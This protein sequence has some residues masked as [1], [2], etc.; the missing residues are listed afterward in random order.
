MNN[1]PR[2]EH[3]FPQFERADW[4]NLNGPWE[5]EIDY[6]ISGKDRKL[7]EKEQLDSEITVPFCPESE[8][9]GVGIKDFLNCVWYQKKVV[10]PAE[11]K[12]K[13]VVLHFGA[14]DYEATV[15][16][17]RKEVGTHV[18]G[19]ISF[20]FDIT[21]YLKDGE[22]V[23]TLCAKDD[24]RSGKQPCGKQCWEYHS[25]G[26]LY[27]RTTG[28][29]QT[30]WLEAMPKAYVKKVKYYPD[31]QSGTI[32]MELETVG[33]GNLDIAVSYEGKEM[34][35]A[36]LTCRGGAR[37]VTIPL[38]E[39]HL[40]E[41][42]HGRLYD[43]TF[44]YGGDQVKS[45]FGLRNVRL[46]GKK[47]L[48]NEK[49][50]FQRLILDQGFYPDGIYTAPTEE[51]L[52]RDIEISM[53]LG[54]NGARLHEKIFEPRFLYHCDRLGY[55]AWGEHANWGL[56]ITDPMTLYHFLPEWM[57]ALERDF[58]HPAIIGWC[59]FNETWDQ[60]G[61]KQY[62]DILRMVYRI[63][64]A[65]DTTRPCID[66]SGNFHVESDIWDVHDYEKDPEVFEKRYNRLMTEGVLEDKFEERQPYH[67]EATFVSEYGGMFTVFGGEEPEGGWG[68]DKPKTEE[69][70]LKRYEALT[71]ALLNN[72]QMFAFCYTQ[73]YDVEQ[74]MN[75][76]YSYDRKAKFDDQVIYRIN[77]K[78]AAIE[79]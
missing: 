47:F 30:V 48:I 8:L 42:G 26:C 18:G 1:I 56:D 76:F 6:S 64:K 68:Y 67:G 41:P 77:T 7:F 21:D 75:G 5:F 2:P 63:T 9:S 55:L 4:M 45:Y 51:A 32:T 70:F 54:F 3:P 14:V 44:T 65:I 36:S 52:I 66:T 11:W 34:G 72:D 73:L 31:H 53:G 15:Y 23:I 17:N 38:K 79:D 60:D 74:E 71:T 16:V 22:N 12:D 19:Y 57:E 62:D 27:T 28:I 39:V 10:I 40:W 58:N 78:K 37:T 69:E 46:D 25:F 50:V 59:P 20:S 13:R 35:Q 61:K 43:V 33:A 29:W 24:N 49:S